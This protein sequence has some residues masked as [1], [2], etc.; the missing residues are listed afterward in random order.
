MTD[1][2]FASIDALLARPR[3]VDDL[4]VPAERERLRKVG[5]YTQEELAAALKTRRE[6]IV[7]WEAGTTDPRPPKREVYIRFLAML[8]LQH[9]TV[10]PAEWLRRAQ[11]AGLVRP[12]VQAPADGPA[13]APPTAV[14]APVPAATVASGPA[15]VRQPGPAPAASATAAPA[16]AVFGGVQQDL[17][18]VELDRTAAGELV[19]G[20]PAPCVRCGRATPYRAQGR[21]MHM[22]GW[23]TPD[24]GIAALVR[25]APAEAVDALVEAST[26]EH[27]TPAQ[28]VERQARLEPAGPSQAALEALARHP[29]IATTAATAA[30]TAPAD[31]PAGA[32]S[33]PAASVAPIAAPRRAAPAPASGPAASSR[34]RKAPAKK[35][36]AAEGSS[37]WEAAAAVRFPAGP[38]AVLDVAADGKSLVAYLADGTVASSAPSGRTLAAVVEW[39]FE[40]KLGSPRLHRRGKDGDAL[41]VVTDA[42]LAELGLPPMGRDEKREFVQRLG[43]LPKTH[44]TVKALEKVGWQL[45][46]RGLG[47]WA[48]IYRTPEDG[49]R[50]C[51]QLCIPAWGALATGGWAIPEG[52]PAPDLARLLGTYATRV[53]IP[54]GSTA[55]SGLELVTALRPPTRAVRTA[56]GWTSGPVEGSRPKDG[57]DPAPPEV[58]DVHPLAQDREEGG[59]LVTEAWDWH[60]DLTDDEQAAPFAVGLDVNMAFLAAAGRLTLP[61]SGP[62]HELNPTFDPKIPGSWLVD[63]SHVDTNPLLPSPFTADGSRP[64]GPAWYSTVK[65]AYAIELGAR[66]Q[67]LEGWLRHEYGPYLDPWH[68][69]LRQAY[70]DT[71]AAL[72]VPLKLADT[73]PVGFLEKM[74]A[75][76]AGQGDAAE[77]AV[78]TAIKQT[79]KGTIGK[80][81][82]RPRGHGYTPGERWAALD[83]PTW[84]PLMRALVIDTATVNLHR[85]LRRMYADTGLHAFAIL[86]DCAVFASPGPGALDVLTKSDGTLTTSLRLGVSPGLVKFEGSRPMPEIAEMLADDVNPARHIKTGGAVS[87]DE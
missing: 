3:P 57:F 54:R 84:D 48:R 67:P 19:A 35:A 14:P 40:A 5:D 11:A 4:P 74:A 70:L 64:T 58:P 21:A 6:T 46:Q 56:V 38:L 30:P 15:V 18:V 47:P 71:M 26:A 73:D 68:K 24:T 51:V 66:P 83:R 33:E 72:G 86:S 29:N 77:L 49:R 17:A 50:Q 27:T 44:K 55:V 60:R 42:A 2:L 63:L 53:L 32:S 59:E 10:E 16:P 81:R 37:D 85:K 79:A 12:T 76:K 34:A 7:R 36:A 69:R 75:I 82:E 78:L 8:A 41:L 80:M 9:G 22:G 13:P 25:G 45:T 28:G 61:L 39:A 65:V 20:P 43:Q 1:D 52:L 87:A 23:C 62:V 31:G